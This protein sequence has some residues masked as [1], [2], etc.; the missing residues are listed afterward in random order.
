MILFHGNCTNKH[1]LG[2]GFAVHKSTVPVVKE[3]KVINPRIIM[4]TIEAQ[5]F[6]ISYISVH[7]PTE[8]KS[9]EDKDSFYKELENILN[10]IS[11]I[12][13][14]FALQNE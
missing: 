13:M 1:Q 10:S 9:Q 3:F 11:G 8:D 12:A 4:L 5:W 6:Y 7:A 2:T 14:F